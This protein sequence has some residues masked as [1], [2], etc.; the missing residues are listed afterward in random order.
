MVDRID[1]F[2][3]FPAFCFYDTQIFAS[4]PN[5]GS[6]LM[7]TSLMNS[8]GNGC[9]MQPPSVKLVMVQK[10]RLHTKT[11]SFEDLNMLKCIEQFNMA[12]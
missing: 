2:Q 9:D 3:S 6:Y 11:S 12:N 1:V 10:N 4:C 8:V 5:L 7:Y